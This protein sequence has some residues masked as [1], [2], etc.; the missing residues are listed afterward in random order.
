MRESQR[1]CKLITGTVTNGRN[2][3]LPAWIRN[4]SATAWPNAVCRSAPRGIQAEAVGRLSWCR[5]RNGVI[6][7]AAPHRGVGR[8][9]WDL[10]GPAA[11]AKGVELEW[12]APVLLII[13]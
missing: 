13:P 12:A 3:E 5:L 7:L 1:A 11:T 8:G 4:G 6:Y 10:T 2:R 9:R